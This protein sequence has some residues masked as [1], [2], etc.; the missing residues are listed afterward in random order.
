MKDSN[1]MHLTEKDLEMAPCLNDGAIG[2]QASAMIS[3]A[4]AV[5]PGPTLSRMKGHAVV[6][7]FGTIERCVELGLDPADE[8]GK[9]FS[10]L[11]TRFDSILSDN[12]PLDLPR[13]EPTASH[14]V[15]EEKTGRHYSRLFGPFN[16]FSFFEEARN[17]L[18]IRFLR[19]GISKNIIE[20]KRVLDAGCGGG[21]YS[22]ALRLLGAGDVI[23]VDVSSDNTSNAS[24][25]VQSAGLTGIKFETANVLE[26]PF[27]DD[28]FDFVF[29]NGVLHHTR[30]WSAGINELLRVLRPDGHGWL[31]LIEN[32]GGLFWD[33]IEVLRVLMKDEASPEIATLLAEGGIPA[34]RIFYMLDHVM[35]P[36]NIRLTKSEIE[37]A[38][39]S[40][41][42]AEIRW[43]N[44]GADFDRVEYLF[45][46]RSFAKELYGEGEQRCVFSKRK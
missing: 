6:E 39:K 4:R 40:S 27:P 21:R 37:E 12:L 26:L 15:I 8:L 23:G 9:T 22:V 3:S 31:Y 32:P 36:I 19:N 7:V 28:Y 29:S 46:N 34:N 10:D 20:G 1:R 5:A 45:Q 24:I 43:L 44:R 16:D 41:G 13:S 38:L 42:A 17:L 25:R 14:E 30:N 33:S 2:K 18:D 11:S 35:V